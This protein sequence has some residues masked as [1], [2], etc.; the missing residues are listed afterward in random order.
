MIKLPSEDTWIDVPPDYSLAN[1][2][3]TRVRQSQEC[4]ALERA[5]GGWGARFQGRVDL[6]GHPETLCVTLKPGGD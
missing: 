4:D 3:W 1:R 6:Q 2:Q 5:L